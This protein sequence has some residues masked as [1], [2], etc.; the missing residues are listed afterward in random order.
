[1]SWTESVVAGV[2]K[3]D[4]T[5]EGFGET[6]QQQNADGEAEGSTILLAQLLGLLIT[7]IGADL[8]LRLV[9]DVWPTI[10]LNDRNFGAEE[11]P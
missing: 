8:T 11:T 6:A 10:P 3:A 5:L 7:F 4:G 9:R 2:I 1:M